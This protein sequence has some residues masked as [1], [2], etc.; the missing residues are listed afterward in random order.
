MALEANRFDLPTIIEYCQSYILKNRLFLCKSGYLVKFDPLKSFSN[1]CSLQK[2]KILGYFEC[3][4]FSSIMNLKRL[5]A[6]MLCEIVVFSFY[7]LSNL[8]IYNIKII[9]R[10][11]ILWMGKYSL[12]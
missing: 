8:K 4:L 1:T 9:G 10:F 7:L 5:Q 12:F 3:L 11:K 6:F 2:E